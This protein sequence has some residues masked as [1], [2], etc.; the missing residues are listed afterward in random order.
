[1]HLRDT[2]FYSR[3]AGRVQLQAF[4][5]IDPYIRA[6]DFEFVQLGPSEMHKLTA[7]EAMEARAPVTRNGAGWYIC[8]YGPGEPRISL[9][10]CSDGDALAV[11]RAFG[12]QAYQLDYE[13]EWSDPC[14]ASTALANWAQAHP[15]KATEWRRLTNYDFWG[16]AARSHD[17][18]VRSASAAQRPASPPS[19]KPDR[20]IASSKQRSAEFREIAS[21]IVRRE[22]AGAPNLGQEIARAL[23][24][25]FQRGAAA[26]LA[27]GEVEPS[28]QNCLPWIQIPPR[29]RSLFG[30]LGLWAFGSPPYVDPARAHDAL[31]VALS[32]PRGRVWALYS[33]NRPG[34][35]DYEA[36]G[37]T[38]FEWSDSTATKLE[39]LGLLELSSMEGGAPCLVLSQFGFNTC[40]NHVATGG[41]FYD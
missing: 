24:A 11:A 31:L 39:K 12:L 41:D 21:A 7:A 29:A 33:R 8:K 38:E 18:G 10:G 23:E 35:P 17:P 6:N 5:D 40:A 34:S 3:T 4:A 16:R 2:L 1:M 32:S 28:T 15:R 9:V 20:P 13:P 36:I 19:R 25:A 37:R 30:T 22:R 27:G 14:E 26:A